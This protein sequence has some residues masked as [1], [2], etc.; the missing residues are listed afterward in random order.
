MLAFLNWRHDEQGKRQLVV[1]WMRRW[2][3][4]V[5]KTLCCVSSL[6]HSS[7]RSWKAVNGCRFAVETS[8]QPT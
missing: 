7:P 2:A 3:P 8:S 4:L 5:W 1:G 6:S